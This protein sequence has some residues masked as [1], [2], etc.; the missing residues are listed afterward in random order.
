MIIMIR[1]AL[2]RKVTSHAPHRA[3]APPPRSL[4]LC[5]LSAHPFCTLM[6]RR[7]RTVGGILGARR[8]QTNKQTDKQTDRQAD[9]TAPSGA[10]PN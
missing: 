9:N 3:R 4:P 5:G 2:P 7:F 1:T 6:V 10:D 8:K